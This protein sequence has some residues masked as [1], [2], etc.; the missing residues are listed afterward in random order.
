MDCLETRWW[1]ALVASFTVKCLTHCYSNTDIL[2]DTSRQLLLA[3][4]QL[5]DPTFILKMC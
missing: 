5:V 4:K 1:T 3:P 2:G